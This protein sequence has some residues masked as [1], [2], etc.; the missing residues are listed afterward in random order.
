MKRTCTCSN[1]WHFCIDASGGRIEA[2]YA[3]CA[4]LVN[5]VLISDVQRLVAYI[6]D[7]L[8]NLEG[9]APD[10]YEY[11]SVPLCVIDAVFSIGVRYTGVTNTID[12]F[13]KFSHWEKDRK[14]ARTEHIVS[15]LLSILSPYENRFDE[16]AENVFRNRQLTSARSGIRKA[17]AVYR[18]AKAL[19][20]HG[21]ETFSD[22]IQRGKDRE[23]GEAVRRIP[24]QSSGLSFAYFLMLVGHRDVVKPDRMLR[25]FVALAIDKPVS[26]DYADDLVVRASAVLRTQFPNL[27]PS[28]LDN[29]I[30]TYQQRAQPR[31]RV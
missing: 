6:S 31:D 28:V 30:W 13:C 24:G 15:Q 12:N 18:F 25:R 11:A 7:K 1:A 19:Q 23:L 27:T 22:A 26:Q 16:L 29:A 14:K 21:I 8:P 17:E 10:N 3:G 2:E 5:P 9:A 4:S 20:H